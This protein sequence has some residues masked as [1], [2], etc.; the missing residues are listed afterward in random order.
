M[1]FKIYNMKSSF[2]NRFLKGLALFIV[3]V[4]TIISCK[5]NPNDPEKSTSILYTSGGRTSEILIVISERLW[6]SPLGDSIK[7]SLLST[8]LWSART[9]SEYIITHIP[10]KAFGDIYQK[11][12]NI[13][14]IKKADIPKPRIELRNN[15]YARPQSLISIRAKN[16]EELTNTFVK[17]QNR[18]KSTFHKNELIRIKNAYKGLEVKSLTNKLDKKFGFHLICPKGFYMAKDAADFA[19]LRRP[20]PD[21]EEGIL[22][23]TRPYTDT[24]D[25]SLNSII[26]NRNQITKKYIPGPVDGSFMKTSSFFPPYYKLTEFK[27]SYAALLRSLWD[28]K[29]YPMGGPFI[30]YTFVD[31]QANRLITLDGYIKAPKKDKRDLM[32]HVEAIINSFEY[33]KTK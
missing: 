24:S 15:V 8:P 4:F 26:D 6:K 12:R 13:I 2:N 14:F 11:Q 3:I 18:I 28:V 30:S 27:G 5:N 17:F 25:F 33:T 20:T 9:E 1:Y 29:G 7:A 31:K 19:W 22:I 16:V 10:Y 23:Y 32:L 21:V